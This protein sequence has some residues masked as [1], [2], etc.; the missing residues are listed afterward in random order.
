MKKFIEINSEIQLLENILSD[1]EIVSERL[2]TIKVCDEFLSLQEQLSDVENTNLCHDFTKIAQKIFDKYLSSVIN[3]DRNRIERIFELWKELDNKVP[4]TDWTLNAFALKEK[5]DQFDCIKNEGNLELT[6]NLFKEIFLLHTFDFA[7]FSFI[8]N[9]NCDFYEVFEYPN[10]FNGSLRS[11]MYQFGLSGRI[12]S[13][14]NAKKRLVVRAILKDLQLK[15]GIQSDKI[16]TLNYKIIGVGT[17][18]FLLFKDSS[19]FKYSENNFNEFRV[20]VEV[21]NSSH[22]LVELKNYKKI[23]ANSIKK[24]KEKNRRY[25]NCCPF[26]WITTVSFGAERKEYS[27]Q[28][29]LSDLYALTHELFILMRQ[30]FIDDGLCE[31][32]VQAILKMM[33][34]NLIKNRIVIGSGKLFRYQDIDLCELEVDLKNIYKYIAS[35]LESNP[36]AKDELN[37]INIFSPSHGINAYK[38]IFTN[39]SLREFLWEYE[40]L[41]SSYIYFSKQLIPLQIGY[42]NGDSLKNI[43]SKRQFSENEVLRYSNDILN[44]LISLRRKGFFYRDLHYENILIDEENDRAVIID[45]ATATNNSDEIYDKNRNFGGNNDLISLGQLMYKMATGNN[46]FNDTNEYSQL[47]HVKDHI[48]TEREQVYSCRNLLEPYFDKISTE[49]NSLVGEIIISILDDDLW[50]QPDLYKYQSI[51]D[52]IQLNIKKL[53]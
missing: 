8:K 27:D 10:E 37:A 1:N 47:A 36:E 35:E 51:K 9:S 15:Y 18:A 21:N 38:N 25:F 29:I 6:L 48:K 22:N 46:L 33:D 26:E 53:Y 13:D 28:T 23:T 24:N 52:A 5:Y 17:T 2:N 32:S 12:V 43:L 30:L 11:M 4:F 49:I 41:L 40:N 20:L 16:I 44:G 34:R 39:N 31:N 19:L 42:I 14:M 3:I 45:L 7:D 50:K